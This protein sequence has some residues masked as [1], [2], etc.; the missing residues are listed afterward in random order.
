MVSRQAEML[1]IAFSK[2]LA[3]IFLLPLS[4]SVGDEFF[5]RLLP[6]IR[7]LRE[8]MMRQSLLTLLYCRRAASMRRR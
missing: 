7:H 2:P 5:S 4:L 6:R 3:L 1:T 8:E